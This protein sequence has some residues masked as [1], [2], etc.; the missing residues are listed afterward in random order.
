M[1]LVCFIP[2][3]L[4]ALLTLILS[5]NEP[6]LMTKPYPSK[7]LYREEIIQ[8]K[9]ATHYN[10]LDSNSGLLKRRTVLLGKKRSESRRGI[11]VT[12][13]GAAHLGEGAATEG[14]RCYHGGAQGT[15]T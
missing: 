9:I 10:R 1:T 3:T 5:Y 7:P 6:Q 14:G 12:Y 8:K 15:G 11:E 2:S 4:V 13:I